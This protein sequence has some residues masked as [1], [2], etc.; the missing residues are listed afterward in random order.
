M[1]YVIVK[2]TNW[3]GLF[4]IIGALSMCI[5]SVFL[6]FFLYEPFLTF[7]IPIYRDTIIMFFLLNFILW[8][9]IFIDLAVNYKPNV[10]K[11]F[12]IRKEKK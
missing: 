1:D 9:W 7:Y 10:E 8:L 3:W 12:Y 6:P 11:I 4:K 2:R 5:V